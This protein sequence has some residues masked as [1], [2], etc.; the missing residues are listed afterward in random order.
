M[1]WQ[2]LFYNDY[3]YY[4]RICS[5]IIE[6]YKADLLV[7]INDRFYY[8]IEMALLKKCKERK[9]PIVIPYIMN[10]NPDTSI[11]M[12]EN[13]SKYMLTK[14]SSFIQKRIFSKYKSQLYKGIY[15]FPSFLIIALERFGTLSKM[16]WLNGGGL[17][18]IV[19]MSNQVGKDMHIN[20]GIEEKKL[21]I[22][23]D[24]S[25]EPVYNSF[26]N[27]KEIKQII[28]KKYELNPKK[29]IM[30]IGLA[31]W[32]E[33][34]MAEKETHFEIVHNTIQNALVY[35]EDYNFLIILHPSMELRNYKFLE[36]MYSIKIANE[37]T[38]NLL[39]IADFYLINYSSTIVWALLCNIKTLIVGYHKKL[40]IYNEFTSVRTV[41]NKSELPQLLK[42]T[43]EDEVDF[44]FDHKLLSKDETFNDKVID[45][46]KKLFFR[47][48]ERGKDD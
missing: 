4:Y 27:R 28:I 36:D 1:I 45:R 18:D 37:K 11:L 12:L 13:N 21:E 23:G 47:M 9:I 10:Y 2:Q 19:V 39:P 32:W 6:D 35:K 43:I 16:P 30:I 26:Q 15:F 34:G 44:S 24:I 46:Y 40:N 17:S 29:K 3:K 22:L 14:E 33:H 25:L 5:K 48:I 20:M 42:E 41:Y 31:N 8:P 38:M 7:T